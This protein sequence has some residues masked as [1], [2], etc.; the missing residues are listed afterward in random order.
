MASVLDQ[1]RP[2]H[3]STSGEGRICSRFFNEYCAVT[4]ATSGEDPRTKRTAR[5]CSEGGVPDLFTGG[6]NAD[7]IGIYPVYQGVNW[8]GR[9]EAS[10]RP[11]VRQESSRS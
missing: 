10:R 4:T 6:R 3:D 7:A 5:F 8:C 9:E 1:S 11:A 2:S